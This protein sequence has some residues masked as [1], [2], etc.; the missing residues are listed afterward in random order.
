VDEAAGGFDG[1]E[2][3]VGSCLLSNFSELYVRVLLLS[4]IVETLKILGM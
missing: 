2:E 1:A 4:L 3:G